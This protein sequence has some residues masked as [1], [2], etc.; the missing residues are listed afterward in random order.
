[1]KIRN[2]VCEGCNLSLEGDITLPKLAMLS[3]ED[4]EFV[5]VFVLSSGSLKD[6]GTILGMSY[7]TVRLRLDKVIENI[8]SLD[9]RQ[10]PKRLEI[11]E[12]LEKGEIMMQ[13]ALDMLKES[14]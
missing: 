8:R 1:M 7:P 10:R 9:E 14:N 2:L 11:L 6:V 4:R 12:K 3:P 13:E 5:E